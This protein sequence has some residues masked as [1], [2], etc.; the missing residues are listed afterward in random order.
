MVN[1]RKNGE[2]AEIGRVKYGPPEGIHR[3]PVGNRGIFLVLF[4]G[5]AY[6]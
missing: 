3:V 6:K 4:P 5:L 1:Q 2:V